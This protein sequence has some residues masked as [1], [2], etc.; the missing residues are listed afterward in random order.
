MRLR[1]LLQTIEDIIPQSIALDWDNVGLLVGDENADIKKVYIALD[2]TDDVLADASAHGADLIITHHPLIFSGL[3]R[4]TAQDFIGRRV[5][6]M[7][8]NNIAYYALHTNFDVQVMGDLACEYL[9]IQGSE[10]LDVTAMDGD[11][12]KGIGC[13]ANLERPM[14]L[15]QMANMCKTSFAV[16]HVKIFGEGTKKIS[17]VA[18]VP[19]S[20]KSE[21]EAA[22]KA[23]ADV[24]ITGDIDHHTGIDAVAQGLAI[25]DAGH[26]GIE[27]IFTE[28]MTNFI[29]GIAPELQ[30]M[31]APIKEPFRIV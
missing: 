11:V 7:I 30:I 23:G 9:D 12:P 21:V 5:M 17:R 31:T 16:S 8:A 6:G 22:V 28:Y 14:D 18:I 1:D 10:I 2:A 27:H 13:V 15:E 24:L 29:Q 20:G 19:G 26:Y 3:K 25:I 4:V